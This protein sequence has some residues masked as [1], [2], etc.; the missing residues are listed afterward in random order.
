MKKKKCDVGRAGR[1]SASSR[2]QKMLK[3]LK[4]REWS[5][6]AQLYAA[7]RSA[8]I[9]ADISDL[10]KNKY[11]IHCLRGGINKHGRRVNKFK[12]VR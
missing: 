2:L 6:P 5:T 1:L 10:R 4:K 9:S 11:V 8:N 7:S 12:L 3:A